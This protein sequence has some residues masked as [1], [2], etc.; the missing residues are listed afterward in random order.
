LPYSFNAV[1]A[2]NAGH[3]DGLRQAVD[4]RFAAD[5]SGL[6]RPRCFPTRLATALPGILRMVAELVAWGSVSRADAA[7]VDV[8]RAEPRL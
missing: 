4:H 3:R 7:S 2:I 8:F 6:S 5:G 1:R